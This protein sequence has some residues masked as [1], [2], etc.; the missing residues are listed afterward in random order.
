MFDAVALQFLSRY[1]GA[2]R[3]TSLMRRLIAVGL[4]HPA[5][6]NHRRVA[7]LNANSVDEMK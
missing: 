4:L 5:S 7:K 2:R 1:G 3:Q 6:V